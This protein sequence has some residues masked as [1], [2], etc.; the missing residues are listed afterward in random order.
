[1]AIGPREKSELEK[2]L[3][4][5]KEPQTQQP[6]FGVD[7]SNSTATAQ[8]PIVP[9]IEQNPFQL[10]SVEPQIDVYADLRAKQPVTMEESVKP[11]VPAAARDANEVK[12]E[13]RPSFDMSGLLEASKNQDELMSR[14]D[15]QIAAARREGPNLGQVLGM[16]F[17]G[18]GESLSGK[19]YLQNTIGQMNTD[20]AKN[21]TNLEKDKALSEE[22]DTR[23][24]ESFI[25]QKYRELAAK[26]TNK[27]PEQFKGMSAYQI[28]KVL[29][30]IK[31]MYDA[32]LKAQQLSESRDFQKKQLQLK[33]L[34]LGIGGVGGKGK[35]LPAPTT[36]AINEGAALARRLPDIEKLI[37]ENPGAFGPVVGRARSLNPYDTTAISIDADM[38]AAS[39]QFGRFMEGGVLRKE[40]EEKYRKMF[41]QRSD[42]PSV[43][44]S[45]LM[46]VQR[47]LAMKYNSDVDTMK[48]SGWDVR[49]FETLST[50][51]SLAERISGPK[52]GTSAFS[53]EDP[54]KEKRYQEWK[55]RQGGQP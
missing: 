24:P 52:G 20:L 32:D 13:N 53:Y 7:I 5:L 48:K 9:P 34:E 23:N 30:T 33:E 14:Y 54:E 17:A 37:D 15:E 3:L 51:E 21:V 1:M 12:P 26:Y 8:G 45:K 25:S 31:D 22:R 47:T 44:K 49:G 38:R 41:P 43:A 27:N 50:P 42:T 28:A 4:Q 29:P 2:F 10:K 40:D 16:G 11:G 35:Q 18:I 39:Q 36:L 6:G 46:N 55:A 19:P